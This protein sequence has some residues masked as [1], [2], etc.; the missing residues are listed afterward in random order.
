MLAEA[1]AELLVELLGERREGP[2]VELGCGGGISAAILT[3]AGHRVLG[4]DLSPDQIA[5]ARER[6][7]DAEFEVCS[8]VD[9]ELPEDALAIALIGEVVNY[10]FDSA[11][12]PRPG[13]RAPPSARSRRSC[14]GASCSSTPPSPAACRT[15]PHPRATWRAT[16]GRSPRGAVEIPAPPM[17]IRE[18]QTVRR[19]PDGIR[20]DSEKHHLLLYRREDVLAMLAEIGFET[21][22]REGYADSLRFPGLPVYIARKPA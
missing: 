15:R 4:T 16:A 20:S 8:F 22:V 14:P 18:I 7:P 17:V 11:Q 21:E 19:G 6:A 2:V 13:A 12:R 10:A 9:A 5:L 3:A 1:G